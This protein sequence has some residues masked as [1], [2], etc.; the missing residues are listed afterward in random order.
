M[1][2]KYCCENMNRWSK[3]DDETPYPL[4]LRTKSG[5]A[6]GIHIN[7]GGESLVTVAYCPW[8]G[9]KISEID[10]ALIGKR[11]VEVT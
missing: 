8:C 1:K 4:I 2:V 10:E 6:V 3:R 7:D 5:N 9:T 11:I